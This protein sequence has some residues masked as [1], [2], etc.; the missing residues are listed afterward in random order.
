[1]ALIETVAN[2]NPIREDLAD[3]IYDISPEETPF[4]SNL[5]RVAVDNTFFEWQTDSLAD[6]TT[7]VAAEGAQAS[8]TGTND[9]V[10]VGNRTEIIERTA[11]T[12]GTVA[13][14][15][16]AGMSKQMAYQ[17]IRRGKEIKRSTEHHLVGIHQAQVSGLSRKTASFAA[18]TS[19]SSDVGDG[20]TGTG[21]GTGLPTP[22]TPRTFDE[23]LLGNVVDAL[24]TAGGNPNVIM[25]PASQKRKLTGFSGNADEVKHANTDMKIINSVSIYVSDYTTM[26]VVPNRFLKTT[27]VLVYEKD[28]WCLGVLRPMQNKEISRI[29]DSDRRQVLQECG[30]MAKNGESSGAIFNL[31]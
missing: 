21:I 22:G 25:A 27:D 2:D 16:N 5:K 31:N 26:A 28:M 11:E 15:D 19:G 6:V 14:V 24:F 23:T 8:F 1:M 17:I 7:A 30:L 4:L 18:W 10:R 3:S 20:S 9:T 29:G 13:A 12:S